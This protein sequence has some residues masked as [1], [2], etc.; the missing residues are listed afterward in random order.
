MR[1]CSILLDSILAATILCIFGDCSGMK[2]TGGTS[3]VG[4]PEKVTGFV[5]DTQRKGIGGVPVRLYKKGYHSRMGIAEYSELYEFGKERVSDSL[6]YDT[7]DSN[8]RF[9]FYGI[10]GGHYNLVGN[11]QEYLLHVYHG[12][13]GV[14]SEHVSLDTVPFREP[15][16]ILVSIPDSV[17]SLRG[18]IVVLGTPI[19][20]PVDSAATV[21][22]S[23]PAGAVN[24]CYLDSAG[25]MQPSVID[26]SLKE[27]YEN[28][29]LDIT[30]Q[31][32]TITPPVVTVPDTA[33][34]YSTVTAQVCCAHSNK[35]HPLEYRFLWG[36]ELSDWNGDTMQT[37][38]FPLQDNMSVLAQARSHLDTL[39][40]SEWSDSCVVVIGPQ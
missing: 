10:P 5:V 21:L 38:V 18:D 40:V 24:L 23:V 26:T 31:L 33:A 39:I 14:D 32:H 3:E 30:N 36:G 19:V 34:V 27:V 2:L 29:T 1:T 25:K 6:F 11:S 8:G 20:Y 16:K 15:A 22:I 17:S 12:N 4:N 28:Y 9:S 7:T 37:H 35:L 13:I